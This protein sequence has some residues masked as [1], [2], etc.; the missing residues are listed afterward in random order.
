MIL[1]ADSGS[2]KADWKIADQGKTYGKFST[3]G[4]NPF[5][6][7]AKTILTALNNSELN[8]FADKIQS[9]KFFGAGCSSPERNKVISKPLQEFFPKAEIVVDHDILGA[10]LAACGDT[11]GITCILGTGSNSCHW[12]GK[13][14][15]S[16]VVPALGNRLGDEGSG[17][18]Y[19]RKILSKY[20]YGLLPEI[21]H[22]TLENEHQ[23]TKEKIFENVYHKAHENVY[24]ASFAKILSKHKDLKFVQNLI[25][26][27]VSEFLDIHVMRYPNVEKTPVHFIGSLAYYFEEITRH[28]CKSKGLTVGKIIKQPIHDLLDYY[29]SK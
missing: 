1:V 24:L 8:Q 27:G 26:E 19:G 10:A 28:V 15:I 23:L 22:Q 13:N 6:H 29:V 14:E 25:L 20:L 16:Q 11:E 3:I 21:L 12:D 18:Y 4:F 17:S 7:D 5:F 2:T 9:V